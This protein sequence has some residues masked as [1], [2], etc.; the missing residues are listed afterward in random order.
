MNHNKGWHQTEETKRKLSEAQLGEK[1]NNW[2]GGISIDAHGYRRVT[3]PP[4]SPYIVMAYSHPSRK[5]MRTILEHRLIMA[6]HLG[7]C[8]ESW[9]VIHHINGD[10]LDNRIENLQLMSGIEHMPFSNWKRHVEQV[11]SEAYEQ[12]K[13]DMLEGLVKVEVSFKVL[14]DGSFL[15]D[16]GIGFEEW[17]KGKW[18]FIPE[19]SDD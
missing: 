19:E 18:V 3:L 13:K 11:R 6:R 12:G 7:R 15:I 8:L 4:E 9:E 5:R 17:T 14:E 10:K 2:K 16:P 1:S